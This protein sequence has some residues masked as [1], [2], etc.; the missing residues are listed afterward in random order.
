MDFSKFLIK[1]YEHWSVYL[2]ENQYYLGRVY[3]WAKREDALDFFDMTNEE[4]E[5]LFKIG[6]QIKTALKKLFSPDL[7]NYAALANIAP[8][9]HLHLIPRY[10]SKKKFAGMVF[11][12]E[13]YGK[14]YAPYNYDF[15]T[16]EAV[17]AQL[18][19][20]LRQELLK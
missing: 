11:E 9:L 4:E 15:K 12:D 3:I 6:K 18:K 20:I 8:H 1:N 14:N 2:H 13:R 19:N 17:L 5:E 16:P 10:S 7:Y